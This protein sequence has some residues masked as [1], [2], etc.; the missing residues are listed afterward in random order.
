M[1]R[2]EF[3]SSGILSTTG[4]LFASKF[5]LAQISAAPRKVL[6][7]GAGLS[8]LV[9]AYELSKAGFDVTIFE[10]QARI[11]GRVLTV[12]D[13]D[14]NLYAEA[15]AARIFHEHDLTL[16]YVKEFGLPLVPFY[17]TEQKFLRMKNGKREEVGWG[18]FTEA[19]DIVMMLEK[20]SYWHKIQGGT[21]LLPRAF[22]RKLA[23][24]I[25]YESP[26]L[27]IEQTSDEVRVTFN[28]R[29]K[30]E[31]L[32]GDYLICA[33][34]FTMLRKIEVLPKFS[35]EKMQVIENLQYDSASRVLLQT[36]R[37]FWSE[38][39]LNGFASG[40]EFAEIWHSTFGQSGTR[41]V[42]QSYL[43]GFFS[44][45]LTKLAP[46]ERIEFTLKS[47]EKLFPEI[48]TNYEKGYTKCWSEDAWFLGAWAHP[49][50]KQAEIIT[51]PENRVF[52]AGEHASNFISWMQG[53]IQSG[54][55]VV[56]E[57]KQKY[58]APHANRIS[59]IKM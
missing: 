30:S 25:K 17:P 22:E 1:K 19:T 32:R 42:L 13:F 7:I 58:P 38:K 9:T 15:G 2:R 55:R 29:G 52:F 26:V 21:D 37:R 56:E 23:G 34:P 39:N 47:L 10:A 6:I 33:I 11:G 8:G 20:Q 3:L 27:K 35:A 28:E 50:G 44:L 36:K 49:L 4:V 12:R 16:K 18:K 14:D 41:G 48:R 57:I 24:K 51:R 54:L 59:W 45:A 46:D 53:A 5:S 31:M 43:R 40:E